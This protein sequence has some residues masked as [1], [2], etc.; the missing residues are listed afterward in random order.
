MQDVLQIH[1]TLMFAALFGILHVIFTLRV[2]AYRFKSG[3]SLGDEGDKELR[4]RI[5]AH[6]NFIENVPIGL[7]LLLLNDLNGLSDT[8]LM[9]LGSVLLAARVLH[10]VMIVSRSLPIVLRPISMLG[11][12]GS[13]LTLA[14]LLLV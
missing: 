3:I 13:I 12:L 5:R 7:I 2:G 1:T 4:N 10:Y 6:G 8:V 14:I 9:V 11:T